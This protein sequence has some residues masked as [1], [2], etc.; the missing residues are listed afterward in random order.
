VPYVLVLLLTMGMRGPD[1]AA[2]TAPSASQQSVDAPGELD[3]LRASC[4]GFSTFASCGE[5]LVTGQPLHFAFGSIAPQDGMGLGLAFVGHKTTPNWRINF[6]ADGVGSFNGSWRGGLYIRLVDTRASTIG[7]QFGSQG[8]T[9]SSNLTELPE[10]PVIGVTIQGLSLAQLNYFGL[11]PQT[12][13]ADAAVFGMREF[14]AGLTALKPIESAL[15]ASVYGEVNARSVD[16]RPRTGQTTPTIGAL[17]DDA[18][19]PGLSQS[20]SFVQ[21]GEGVRIR[22]DLFS[23]LL[24][25][26]YDV[27]LR[28]FVSLSDSSFTFHRLVVDLSHDIALYRSTTRTLLPRDANGPDECALSADPAQPSCAVDTKALHD[29]CLKTAS[30]PSACDAITRDLQGDVGFRI[31]YS[32]S[33]TPAGHVVPFYFQPTLGGSDVNGNSML[34]SYQDYRFRAPTALLLRQSFEQSLWGP[35]GFALMLDEGKVASRATTLGSSP[36][37]YTVSAGL[38]VRAGGAP[39]VYVLYSR[40]GPEGTHTSFTINTSLL[41]GS[42]RP[43]VF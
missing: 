35:I 32:D 36:W 25:L 7:V 9:P 23:D 18:T 27:S 20:Q 41:G 34:A 33:L 3:K 24:R 39:E 4:G 15:H 1:Q 30:T 38:T 31:L 14:I 19:A 16:V 11:G 40:G 6:D 17:Y 13:T 37:L 12:T 29:A 8:M 42:A 26:N 21:F 10:H 22:P 28:D 43:S 2:P 5:E